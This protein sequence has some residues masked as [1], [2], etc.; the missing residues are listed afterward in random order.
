MPCTSDYARVGNINERRKL[1]LKELTSGGVA[2]HKAISLV[3]VSATECGYIWNQARVAPPVLE[4]ELSTCWQCRSCVGWE[5]ALKNGRK[6]LHP[7][8]KEP[9]ARA[10]LLDN[11]MATVGADGDLLPAGPL[12]AANSDA[13]AKWF[14]WAVRNRR[15]DLL[16]NWSIGPTQMHL[17]WS[18][19]FRPFMKMGP[20]PNRLNTWEQVFEF[21]T[22]SSAAARG[23]AI[24]YLDP[25]SPGMANT[26]WPA[27][28]PDDK[29]K[30]ITWLIGQVGN[31]N[32]ATTY[33]NNAY[34][35]NLKA[36]LADAKL[37]NVV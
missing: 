23:H 2:A 19:L 29:E 35:N 11:K 7:N 9:V 27:A 20:T 37:L 24:K 22:A 17:I 30:V 18:D 32:A 25:G 21:Y 16:T 5:F 14:E 10:F 15:A 34:A 3:A 13:I 12:L 1:A 4:F 33:Y 6:I 26:S 28:N 8:N 31:R 36:T